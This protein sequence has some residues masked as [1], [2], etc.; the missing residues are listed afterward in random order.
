VELVGRFMARN[1]EDRPA[2]ASGC[3]DLITRLAA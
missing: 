2:D 1:R 3:L